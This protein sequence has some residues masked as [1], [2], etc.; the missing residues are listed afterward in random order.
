[1]ILSLKNF[2]SAKI[3]QRNEIPKDGRVIKTLVWQYAVA[4]VSVKYILNFK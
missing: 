3:I 1:M 2:P 4:N